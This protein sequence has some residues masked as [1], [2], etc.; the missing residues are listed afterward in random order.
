MKKIL[1]LALSIM[2]T[3]S[4]V[5]CKSEDEIKADV[6]AAVQKKVDQIYTQDEDFAAAMD[7]ITNK[8]WSCVAGTDG[9]YVVILTGTMTYIVSANVSV[10]F[11]VD[12]NTEKLTKMTI[13][14]MGTTEEIEIPE[15]S[16]RA[17][18]DI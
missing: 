6:I 7:S 11:T 5:G 14:A 8:E 4:M 2:M 10:R 18:L 1:A 17:D 16:D 13:S 15:D 3:L 12:T 9:E